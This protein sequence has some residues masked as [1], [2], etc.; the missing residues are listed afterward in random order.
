MEKV[1]ELGGAA[2]IAGLAYMKE[3]LVASNTARLKAIETG[4]T[5]VVG[6]NVF[7]TT[8]A[9][10]LSTGNAILTVKDDVEFGQIERLKAWRAKRDGAM[11][12]Q[13]LAELRAAAIEG[14]NIMEPSIACAKAGVTTGEW[15]GTLRQVFGEFRGPT[16]VSLG[17]ADDASHEGLRE[18]VAKLAQVIGTK[19]KFLVGKPGLDGHSNGAE[20]IATRAADIGLSVIYDGIRLTPD[21]LVEK[22]AAENVHLLGL[23]VLSGSHVPLVREVMRQLRT[24]NISVPVVVGGIIPE[25]DAHVL[26][27]LGVSQVYTPKDFDLDKIM[28]GLVGLLE[29]SCTTA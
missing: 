14:R 9:S 6:V 26:K 4:E 2:S 23:S 12:T 27:Q 19:P 24:R 13:A 22:V 20:Q 17:S 21:E 5:K 11:V 29:V 25:E 3:A 18:R 16:G 8:E 7:T 1:A 10:P 28:D 15:G